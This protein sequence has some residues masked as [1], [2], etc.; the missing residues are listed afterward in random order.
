MVYPYSS[1][2]REM[3]M[4]LDEHSLRL[5]GSKSF[6]ALASEKY[7]KED[8][9]AFIYEEELSHSMQDISASQQPS[10]SHR[11][12]IAQIREDIGRFTA[13]ENPPIPATSSRWNKFMCES[14]S[15]EEEESSKVSSSN[16]VLSSKSAVASY[17][18]EQTESV[19]SS[20]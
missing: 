15:E 10:T 12:Q 19:E 1:I 4:L 17:T 5:K 11:E 8:E 7:H 13:S 18:L 20:D 14:E 16:H 6:H 2:S 3:E 9:D